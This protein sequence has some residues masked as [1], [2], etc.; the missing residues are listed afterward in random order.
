MIELVSTSISGLYQLKPKLIKDERGYFFR[1]YCKKELKG[2]CKGTEFV[3]GNQ[4][5]T[6]AKGAVRGLHFQKPPHAEDK[7]VRCLAGRVFDVAVD[8]RTGSST[9]LSW[10][11]CELNSEAHNM[12]YIPR[13]FAHGFQT[14]EENCTMLYL[15]SE[16]YSSDSEAGVH[17]ND[18]R[19]KISWPL[20]V[21]Q[22]SDRDQ[23]FGPLTD[24]FG[25]LAV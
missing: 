3:Q 7:L 11:G 14:L 16:Y 2:V 6:R 17:I 8:L 20:P 22:L 4:T 24:D 12:L 15:H 5:L 10:F 21:S 23:T 13:G 9:F 1:Y 19:L 25:G 18:S